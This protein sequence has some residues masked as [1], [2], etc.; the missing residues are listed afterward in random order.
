MLKSLPVQLII[1]IFAAFLLSDV[2]NLETLR[3][4]FSISCSLKEI[5][6][7]VLPFVIFSYITAAILSMEQRAPWLIFS[8]L[9]LVTLS[10]AFT[11]L[12]SYG[13][14]VSLLPLL[15]FGNTSSL[16]AIQDTVTPL[17]SL[18]IPEILAPDQSLLL[19]IVVG[20]IFSFIKVPA[21]TTLAQ[22]MRH[23]VTVFLQKAF[24]PLL[25]LYV[26]GFIL[27]MDYEDTLMI[28][29]KNSGHIFGLVW[30]FIVVYLALLYFIVSGFRLSRFF[31]LV[32]NMLPA[33]ITGF[34]TMSS[35]ATMP[36]TLAATE[37][38]MGDD[39]FA[40]LVIPTTVNIHLMGDALAI[41][42]LALAVL[43]L[44]GLPL[45]TFENYLLFVVYF[46]LAKFSVAGI[47]GG[48]IIV[49]LPILQKYL[50]LTP[51]MA[52]LLTTIYIIQDPIFTSANVMGNG[53]FA[54]LVRKVTG[55][56]NK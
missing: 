50:G 49:M 17:F 10:N 30:I 20:L 55:R 5:L 29:I 6:M 26:F 45:P 27:K 9:A 25:P 13:V 3:F 7:G 18:H 8:I 34:S 33:G 39:Q 4:F 53:A 56:E 1:A 21:V 51:E 35:A 32:R 37:K 14:G 52:S 11:V 15:T 22:S 36:V 44:S 48:G 46:C 40:D 28:L 54:L 12:V 47:P 41:P 24:I 43:S 42:I 38:N 2:F 19:G 16:S 23:Y 31:E